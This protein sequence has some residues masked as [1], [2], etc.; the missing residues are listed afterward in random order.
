MNVLPD[1]YIYLPPQEEECTSSSLGDSK[2]Y[3]SGSIANLQRML[4]E[5]NKSGAIA[6]KGLEWKVINITGRVSQTLKDIQ[7]YF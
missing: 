6:K 4:S 5:I 2:M 7:N 3:T 1:V